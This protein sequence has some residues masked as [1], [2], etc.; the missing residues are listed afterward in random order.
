MHQ[1]TILNDKPE[2]RE[3]FAGFDIQ[4]VELIYS[5]TGGKRSKPDKE[6]IIRNSG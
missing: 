6:L 4:P 5:V 3:L 2:V 1:F